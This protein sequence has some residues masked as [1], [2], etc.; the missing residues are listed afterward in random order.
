M[1]Q[2]LPVGKELMFC[3]MAFKELVSCNE[4]RS[5]LVSIVRRTRFSLEEG[6]TG[7]HEQNGNTGVH[8]EFNWKENPPLLCCWKKLLKSVDSKDG[9]SSNAVEAVSA[10]SLG[11][12]CFCL[13]GKR[14]VNCDT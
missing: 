8:N 6:F 13:D 5:A 4:G 2:V 3:L 7:G 14:S 11:S 12:L 10:L 1:V 9:L